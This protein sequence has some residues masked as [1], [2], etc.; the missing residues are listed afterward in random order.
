MINLF[1]RDRLVGL[2]IKNVHLL[3]NVSQMI[4]FTSPYKRK[5]LYSIN[6]IFKL[7]VYRTLCKHN[8]TLINTVKSRLRH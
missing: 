3:Y 6:N 2:E 8:K 7:S 1:V 4:K 5:I